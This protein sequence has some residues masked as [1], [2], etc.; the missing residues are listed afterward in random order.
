MPIDKQKLKTY[1]NALGV[2]KPV[3]YGD[4]TERK[5]Y[6]E[7]LHG[8]RNVVDALFNAIDLQDG[9]GV[10]LFSGQRGSGKSTELKRLK[11]LL[12]TDPTIDCKVFYLDMQEWLNPA[13][14]V[15]LGSF[16]VAVA[17]AWVHQ[18]KTTDAQLS[19][20]QRFWDFL[21]NTQIDISG[22]NLGVGSGDVKADLQISLHT[23]E[24][25]LQE[26]AKLTQKHKTRFIGQAKEFIS[27]LAHDLCGDKSKCVLLIDQLEKINGNGSNTEEVLTSVLNL[28]AN[29]SDALQLPLVHAVYSIPPYVLEQNKNLAAVLGATATVQLPSVHV[30][31]RES[32]D[33]D[34]VYVARVVDLVAR[35][36]PDWREFFSL[37]QLQTLVLETG[38]D[39]RDL[40]RALQNC[41]L[42]ISDATPQVND[43][44]LDFARSQVRPTL[45]IPI[46]HM[47]WMARIDG[48]HRSE[49]NEQ[50]SALLLEKYLTTKHVLAYLNGQTWYG[51]NPL[52]RQEVLSQAAQYVKAQD[53]S[54][55]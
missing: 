19:P 16:V 42:K 32:S 5:K 36:C 7:G 10:F 37:A 46:E 35:R 55:A 18:A 34:P 52:I 44:A 17:A 8:D 53:D 41:L 9:Q 6:V 54:A 22:L 39:L 12:E 21:K 14:P 40:L 45:V 2:Q 3:D 33:A 27:Q 25:F 48:S 4:A 24:S 13:R 29:N 11:Y 30:F 15:E 43:E 1:F 51:L 20:A 49:T 50:Y 26:I 31:K 28:F 23:D 47:V 38:G